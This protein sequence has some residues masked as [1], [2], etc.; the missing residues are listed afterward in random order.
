[1]W[2]QIANTVLGIWMMVAPSVLNYGKAA[3]NNA[4]I[5]GSLIATTAIIAI[6]ESVRSVRWGNSIFGLWL[7]LAPWI[8]DFE[9][10]EIINDMATGILVFVFS[11]VKG[12]IKEKMGGGWK[13]A[14]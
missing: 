6:A 7:I 8:V 4:Y 13:T 5:F 1:M 11:F 12:N 14:F 9:K 2:A 10:A 3:S